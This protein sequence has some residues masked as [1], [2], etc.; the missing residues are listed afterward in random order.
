[1][2]K[3]K[4]LEEVDLPKIFKDQNKFIHFQS[5]K[6]HV[7]AKNVLDEKNAKEMFIFLKKNMK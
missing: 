3:V 2:V 5:K 6:F 4:N 7:R 1:L